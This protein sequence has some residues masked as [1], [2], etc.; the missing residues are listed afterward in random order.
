[1]HDF[2]MYLYIN[3][4]KSVNLIYSL[5]SEAGLPVFLGYPTIKINSIFTFYTFLHNITHK[6]NSFSSADRLSSLSSEDWCQFL[7]QVC[8]VLESVDRAGSAS[9]TVP[10]AK[11]NLLCYL[12]TICNHRE[13]AT[14]LIHSQ[15]V[16]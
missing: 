11:L 8:A 7:Q 2:K 13:T 10:R 15:L 1:M 9:A 12:C 6:L 3:L 4:L 16:R 5:T 14:R